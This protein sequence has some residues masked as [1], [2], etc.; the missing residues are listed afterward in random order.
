[1]KKS[2]ITII[3]TSAVTVVVIAVVIVALMPVIGP[4]FLRPLMSG[5]IPGQPNASATAAPPSA[6]A[7]PGPTPSPVSPLNISAGPALG[8]QPAGDLI[9]R[10]SS[11]PNPPLRGRNALEVLIT[12][13]DGQPVSDAVV[14]FDIDMTNMS[15]G[16]YVVS[17]APQENGR[18]AGEVSFL[19]PGPWRAIVSVE[20]PGRTVESARFDFQVNFVGAATAGLAAAA[21]LGL[22]ATALSGWTGYYL[23]RFK[24]GMTEMLGM[25]IGMTLGMMTGIVVGY[26]FGAVADMFISNLIGVLVGVAFGIAFGR[27]GGLM[28]MMDG[29]MGGMM[30]GMMGAMLGVMLQYDTRYI[31]IT[32]MVTMALYLAALGALIRLVRAGALRETVVDPVCKMT[33]DVR[34]SLTSTHGG[35]AFYFCAPACQK[36]FDKNPEAYQ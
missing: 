10:L 4:R 21:A 25:M 8:S 27:L 26:L 29:A 12:G 19:M 36:A 35:R 20:R 2:A 31:V 3:A 13:A 30:G 22:L 5:A 28:G 33:V 34:R 18:Y 32:G 9:V 11:A 24:S 14:T 1:M 6:N 23:L 16:K 7:Y 17:A 15:H